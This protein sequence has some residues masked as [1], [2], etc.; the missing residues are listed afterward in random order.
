MLFWVSGM[1]FD[2]L[3][4]CCLESRQDMLVDFS[5]V[6]GCVLGAPFQGQRYLLTMLGFFFVM[7]KAP[8]NSVA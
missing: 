6:L 2:D 3:R 1:A 7:S 4:S 5:G 8:P